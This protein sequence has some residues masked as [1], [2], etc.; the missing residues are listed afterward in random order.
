MLTLLKRLSILVIGLFSL[1]FIS[2]LTLS[3][4]SEVAEQPAVNISSAPPQ[5]KAITQLW[6]M[7]QLREMS[8]DTLIDFPYDNYYQKPMTFSAY[9]LQPLIDQILEEV[10]QPEDYALIFRCSDGYNK[11]ISLTTFIE[12]PSYIVF[13]DDESGGV[14]TISSKL[15]KYYLTW[16]EMAPGNELPYPYQVAKVELI[17]ASA[18][19][20]NSY[21]VDV[22]SNEQLAFGFKTFN[23]YCRSCHS[24]NKEGGDLGP[25]LNVPQNIT[26]YRSQ[27]FIQAFV[28]NPQQYRYNSKMAPVRL[29]DE[30]FE[31][32]Y[33]YLEAM[34]DHQIAL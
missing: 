29:S 6:S 12:N 26:T 16:D 21:P 15:G 34:A 23:K 13:K 17:E 31:A 19:F 33:G 25:E 32:V 27:T 7:T 11:D 3:C 9:S 20:I 4:T 30:E 24:I 2:Q 14:D 22:A 5:E 8:N 18:L 28:S 10:E 1:V